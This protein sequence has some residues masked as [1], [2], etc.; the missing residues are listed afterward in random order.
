MIAT[1]SKPAAPA[2]RPRALSWRGCGASWRRHRC[3]I[4]RRIDDLRP[5]AATRAKRESVEGNW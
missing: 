2:W 3:R 1:R 5:R 4:R